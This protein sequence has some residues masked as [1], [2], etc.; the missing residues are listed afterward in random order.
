[1]PT[2]LHSSLTSSELHEP[3]GADTATSGQVYV[4]NGSGSGSWTTWP[5]GWG[6]YKDNASAQTF[7]TTHAKLSI[8]GAGSATN[9]TQLPLV[10]RGSGALWDTTNDKITP[11]VAGDSYDIRI[12][13]PVT[14]KT[15]SPSSLSLQLDIGGG[16]TPTTVIV[17]KELSLNNTPPYTLNV[18]FPIFSLSTFKT[19]GGQL[20]IG[21][22]T[23]TVDITAPAVFIK[24]DHAAD[25]A[26]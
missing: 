9:V 20:F 3:K 4:S 26:T 10:I 18:A 6:Y 12:D 24:R 7:N 22:D 14:A 5:L 2:V 21:T 17:E 15:G 13:L 25:F 19:N 16:A 1:M 23:G 11:V 8:D